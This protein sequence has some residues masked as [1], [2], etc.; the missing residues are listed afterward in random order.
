MIAAALHGSE[1][2]VDFDFRS[3]GLRVVMNLML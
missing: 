2:S 1:G 3:E